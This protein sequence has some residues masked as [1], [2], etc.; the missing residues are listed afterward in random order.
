MRLLIPFGLVA[1]AGTAV[2]AEDLAQRG[3]YGYE[4]LAHRIDECSHLKSDSIISL[5]EII[6]AIEAN[7]DG[8]RRE[9]S[10]QSSADLERSRQI[11]ESLKKCFPERIECRGGP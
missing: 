2:A 5:D 4:T 10:A 3:P 8:F 9:A 7:E 1:V 11:R 6:M